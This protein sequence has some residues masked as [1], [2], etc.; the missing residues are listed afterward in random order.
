[1]GAAPPPWALRRELRP[2]T[3]TTGEMFGGTELQILI[4]AGDLCACALVFLLP[5]WKSSTGTGLYTEKCYF[6]PV[7]D[8]RN[9]AEKSA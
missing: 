8:D 2:A 7:K 6:E 5:M 4:S 3:S 9:T 1:M